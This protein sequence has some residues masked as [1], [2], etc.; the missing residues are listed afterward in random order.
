MT[1]PQP[2]SPATP[3]AEDDLTRILF[4]HS[5]FQYLRAGTELGLFDLLE[6]R[7]GLDRKELATALELQDRALDILLLGVT[8]LRLVDQSDDTY[9]NNQT[10]SR[11]FAE[12][13]WE[14]VTAVIGFEAYV[15]YP[16]LA[17]FTES[18]R[19][20]TN[21]GL[22]RVP[23]PGPTLYHRLT[24]DPELSKVFYRYMG[25]WSAMAAGY[26][27]SSVD[28]GSLNRVLDVG[29][30]DATIAVAVAQAFPHL[31][32]TVLEL[33]GVVPLAQRRVDEAGVGDRVKVIATDMFADP[34]PADHDGA[35]FVHQMQIWPLDQD[36][37]LLRRAH[38]ALPSG[39]SVVIMNS[40]SDDTGDGPLMAALDAAYFAAI[41]GGG[42]MIYA[43]RKYE[44]CLRA[45]GFGAIERIR[46]AG[47]WTPHGVIVAK[48]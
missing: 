9:R 3:L 27:I 36:T 14:V 24:A 5:A 29:G 38:E 45:A 4:G 8:A 44:Q 17:D 15:N 7:P 33:P 18:L 28:F 41:P 25:T 32:I 23:G 47:A 22:R 46:P 37:E 11:L 34:F 21:V 39:G 1:D 16:G 31:Q 42:G 30:G 43:W 20:N 12:G 2:P 6:R 19:T 40:M 10:V 48:K 13:R 26:L 35:L